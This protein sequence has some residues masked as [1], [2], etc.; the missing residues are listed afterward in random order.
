MKTSMVKRTIKY[1]LLTTT[2]CVLTFLYLV[3]FGENRISLILNQGV[4]VPHNLHDISI[5]RRRGLIAVLF[6]SDAH[7]IATCKTTKKNLMDWLKTSNF[8][9]IHFYRDTSFK[10]IFYTSYDSLP[11][12]IIQN[13]IDYTIQLQRTSSDTRHLNI[14]PIDNDNVFLKYEMDWN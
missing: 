3:Y 5:E 1:I 14:E 6:T 8:E 4:N 11:L 7:T 2:L 10:E 12:E 13:K 9:V